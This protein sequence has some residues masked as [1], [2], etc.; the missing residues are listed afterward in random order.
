M[1]WQNQRLRL[2]ISVLFVPS[3]ICACSCCGFSAGLHLLQWWSAVLIHLTPN[4]PPQP[5][6]SA[7]L[8]SRLCMKLQCACPC[9][10]GGQHQAALCQGTG[11]R[12]RGGG[13][14]VSRQHAAAVILLCGISF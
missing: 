6:L 5:H 12:W 4:L 11:R 8:G 9:T 7:A 14:I 2:A 10:L 13:G 1:C 3:G